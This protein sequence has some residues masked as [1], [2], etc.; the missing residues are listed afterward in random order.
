V[1]TKTETPHVENVLNGDLDQ[2][3]ESY[4]RYKALNS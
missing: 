1:R 3:I 4:L 2:F